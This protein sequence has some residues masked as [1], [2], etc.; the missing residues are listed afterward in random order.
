M[1]GE[2]NSTVDEEAAILAAIMTIDGGYDRVAIKLRP[3]HFSE[4]LFARIYEQ[5]GALSDAG[6]AINIFTVSNAMSAEPSFVDLGGHAYWLN[7]ANQPFVMG[8]LT[9]AD[10]LIAQARRRLLIE[11][12]RDATECASDRSIDLGEALQVM[13]AGMADAMPAEITGRTKRL[14]RAY[15]DALQRIEA[16]RNGEVSAG[17]CVYGWSD[18]DDLTGGIRAGEYLLVGGRPSMGKTALSLGIA[19]RAAQAGHGVLYISREMSTPALM[20]RMLADLLFDLGGEAGMTE[21][22]AGNVSPA[23]LQRLWRAQQDIDRWPLVIDD[24][25]TLSAGQI[26]PLIRRHK[27]AFERRGE[28]LDLVIIDY[29]GLVDP[30]PGKGNRQ[31]E[32]TATSK[33]IKNAARSTGVPI[34]VLS[35]LSRA[36]EQREDKRPQLSDL[37]ESGSLEQDADVVIFVYRDQY[38]LERAEP[39]PT[40]A[41]RRSSWEVD[42]EAARDRIDIYTAKQRQGA[43]VRRK[44]YFFGARQAIRNSDYYSTGG[45]R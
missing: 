42:M 30:P 8:A 11:S 1:A 43:L 23:D 39:D 6:K 14:G 26:G 33:A 24:P 37:R 27:K 13:E 15:A 45:G 28:S 17:L 22:R 21:I 40:D 16:L 29:L 12:L 18:F 5:M 4:P 25:E 19:R 2:K 41:K 10:D 38:Y 36:L 32:V 3:E 20:E 31:E 44:G 9:F 7:V 35:Q 34:I